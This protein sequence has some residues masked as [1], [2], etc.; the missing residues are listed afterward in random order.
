[1][2]LRL[3]RFICCV[4]VSSDQLGGEL[5]GE[6]ANER[7]KI[8][9]WS[10]RSEPETTGLIGASAIVVPFAQQSPRG[11][12]DQVG[13]QANPLGRSTAYSG[14]ARERSEFGSAFRYRPGTV[15]RC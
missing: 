15:L 4:N 14:V 8:H 6:Q 1:M 5:L 9:R 13:E 2:D 10:R 12:L 7:L 3:R 11:S